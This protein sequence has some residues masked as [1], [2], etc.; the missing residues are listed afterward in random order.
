MKQTLEFLVQHGYA[1]LFVSVLIEQLGVPLPSIPILLAMGALAGL[2][3]FSYSLALLL[4]VIACVIADGTWYLLGVYRGRS[5][6]KLLCKI[7]LEP[8][9]CVRNTENMFLKFGP[10]V[11]LFSKF[12]PGLS[13]A[14][15]PLAGMFRMKIWKFCLFDGL[16]SLLWAGSYSALGYVFRGQLEDLAQKALGLGSWLLTLI[17]TAVCGWLLWKYI[18][19]RRFYRELYIARITPQELL[20]LINADAPLT[21]LDV[22]NAMEWTVEGASKLPGAL[23]MS[24]EDLDRRLP[25]IPLDR[26]V[27]LYCT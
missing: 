3:S 19:R 13:T 7:S 6:L 16:G 8:D 12:V 22:R 2:G 9:S 25:E 21:L 20:D 10:R 4:A 5:I 14:A 23:H 18:A 24:F 11:L 1:L 26:D 15:T 27:I 17:V